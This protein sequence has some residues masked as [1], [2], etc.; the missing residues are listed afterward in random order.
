MPFYF[1]LRSYKHTTRPLIFDNNFLNNPD[2]NNK[3]DKIEN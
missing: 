2:F 1:F 3:S